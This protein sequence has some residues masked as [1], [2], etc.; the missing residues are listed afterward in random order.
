[1]RNVR[2]RRGRGSNDDAFGSPVSGKVL[3]MSGRCVTTGPLGDADIVGLCGRK[4]LA[5]QQTQLTARAPRRRM[6]G[7]GVACAAGDCVAACSRSRAGTHR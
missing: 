5:A 7:S 6:S 2:T 3:S 4:P 1:M